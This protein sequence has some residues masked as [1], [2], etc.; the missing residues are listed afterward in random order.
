METKKMRLQEM[1][2]PVQVISSP[3][4]VYLVPGRAQQSKNFAVERKETLGWMK[5]TSA[6]VGSSHR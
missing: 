1:R 4:S 2:S 3:P 5:R 6:V